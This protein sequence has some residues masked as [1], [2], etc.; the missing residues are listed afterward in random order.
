MAR[1]PTVTVTGGNGNGRPAGEG[2]GGFEA[3][4][5]LTLKGRTQ[6]V[7]LAVMFDGYDT[8]RATAVGKLTLRRTAFD[9]G[10]G[11]WAATDTVADGVVVDF[12]LA[13]VAIPTN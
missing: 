1:L 9:V 7:H 5:T 4:G 8:T 12:V 2:E 10:T 13:A 3:D 11:Q 6:P